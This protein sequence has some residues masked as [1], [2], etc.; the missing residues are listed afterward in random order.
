MSEKWKPIPGFAG[1]DVSSEGRVRSFW[2]VGR[3]AKIDGS[4]PT[5]KSTYLDKDGYCLVCL[6]SNRKQTTCKVHRLVLMAFSGECPDGMESCHNNGSRSDNRI[7]NLRWDTKSSN[8]SDRVIHGTSQHGQRHNMAKLSSSQVSEIR[9]LF[10][11]K[12]ESRKDLASRFNVS[13][14]QIG[15]IVT[16]RKWKEVA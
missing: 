10:S 1:Y 7:E 6:N 9:E 2:T 15:N 11:L 13:I 16:G 4:K 5:I 12:K 14:S 3:F 8:Q